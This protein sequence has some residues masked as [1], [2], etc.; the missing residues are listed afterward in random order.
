MRVTE[1][2]DGAIMAPPIEPPADGPP[3]EI[4]LT[5]ARFGGSP[6]RKR[7]WTARR[8]DAPD[9]VPPSTGPSG[10]VGVS[11]ARFSGA[12]LEDDEQA[13][14]RQGPV[15]DDAYGPGYP[16][17]VPPVPE[18]PAVQS[19]LSV[20]R[21]YVLTR[22]R[23]RPR[24]DLAIEALV[25]AVPGSAPAHE[26]IEHARIRELTTSPRSV[27]EVAAL[28]AVPLGVARVLLADLAEAGGVRVHSTADAGNGPD[29]T[30]MQRVL[31]GLRRL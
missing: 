23:T 29:L 11:G 4:G 21:P 1:R 25:S 8:D 27:A 12:P 26:S 19:S 3:P 13:A 22:G 24:I 9:P 30:L 5:G 10:Q 6:R 7:R 18:M 17:T 20:V 31:S 15:A 16:V 28:M 2:D 14:E